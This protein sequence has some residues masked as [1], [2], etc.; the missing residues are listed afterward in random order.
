[1]KND[2]DST[3]GKW[4]LGIIKEMKIKVWGK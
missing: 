2:A 3:G 4:V 1:M